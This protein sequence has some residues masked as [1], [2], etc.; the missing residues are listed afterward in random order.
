M[1]KQLMNLELYNLVE[2][3]TNVRTNTTTK[4]KFNCLPFK[5]QYAL[6]SNM[7]TI[8]KAIEPFKELRDEYVEPLRAEYFTE[9]RTDKKT[10]KGEDGNEQEVVQLKAEYIPEF[11]DKL[12]VVNEKLQEVL[13]E[14]VDVQVICYDFDTLV[15][16]LDDK[17][18]EKY[19]MTLD[20]FNMLEFM[21]VNGEQEETVEP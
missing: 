16:E 10:V 8:E 18:I 2:W 15:D 9:D 3:Y 6:K 19:N 20:D 1:T 17:E 11:Q 21:N 13:L 7:K 4:D 5:V 14:K 12:K